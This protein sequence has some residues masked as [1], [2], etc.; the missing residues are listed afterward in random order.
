MGVEVAGSELPKA[1][2]EVKTKV[3]EQENGKINFAEVIT[4]GSHGVDEVKPG[5][6]A[7]DVSSVNI[8][9]NAVDEWPEEAQTHHFYFVKHRQWDDPKL[10]AEFEL[11]EKEIQKK[12]VQI[13]QIIEEL[14]AKKSEKFELLDEVKAFNDENAQYWAFINEKR[15]EIKPLQ[16]A[17]GSL[18]GGGGGE[19]G[20][21]ICSSEEELNQ[22][23]RS[24]E[25]RMQ[26][27]SM[28]LK[29]EK[30]LMR[31]LKELE[32]TRPKVIA[33]SAMRAKIQESMG[34]KE[35][36]QDQVKLLGTDL[37][38][39]RKQQAATKA[40]IDRLTPQLNAL[41]AQ[42]EKLGDE[43]KAVKDKKEV[44]IA[45]VQQ[46]RKKRDAGNAYFYESR[47]ILN[48]AKEI[49]V[50][51]DV[52]ALE[53]YNNAEV[54]KFMSLWNSSKAFRDDYEK[55]MLSSLDY[56]QLSRD[57]R[58]RNF[59]EKP[60]VRVEPQRP[61]EADLGSKAPLKQ[62]KEVVK[63]TPKVES[64]PAEK[65]QKESK[66][67]SKE[68]KTAS[69]RAVEEEEVFVVQKPKKDVSKDNGIDA[70]KLKEMKKE[71]EKEKQRQAFE[72]KKKLQEK[73]AAKAAL[74]A[75]KEAEK[76][77]KDR[78][79]KMKKKTVQPSNEDEATEKSE[80]DEPERSDEVEEVVETP[81]ASKSKVQQDNTLRHRKPIR[82]RG[83]LPKAM[84]KKKKSDKYWLWGS[85]AAAVFGVL[86]LVALGYK[87]YL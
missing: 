83:T 43:L 76:K 68:S 69:E 24:I 29:E 52:K 40:K 45:T 25:Y 71:E 12:N 4:F 56:R 13:G 50:R 15:E 19:K 87:Y 47:T 58:I 42:I 26:H 84:I 34:Q 57:G 20:S 6:E 9:K 78:E 70:E 86:M 1:N 11:T 8:A 44:A 33:K 72:R 36:I 73:A 63:T 23:I 46:L 3:H 61:S 28:P 5:G 32:A 16:T 85:I 35:A 74:R 37:D 14:R 31:E 60:L 62:Q 82:S 2:G 48:K 10:K 81:A 27:E 17:L 21:S 18:R 7:N 51:K 55:R 77:Q 75:Q 49:A 67:G 80:T 54:E 65:A 41:N 38:G 66:K 39:V 79:K 64:L 22:L 30:Q 59:D 53:E